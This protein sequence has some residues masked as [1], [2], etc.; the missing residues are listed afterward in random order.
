MESVKTYEQLLEE[1][2]LL[3]IR[4]EEANDTLEAIRSGEVD[5]LVVKANDSHQLYT[6]K[7][8]DQTYR[9]FIEQMTEGV[10]TL[11]SKN[12]ILYCN[13]R[14]A[15]MVG[16][17]LEKIIG[18]EFCKFILQD[19]WHACEQL[20]NRAWED[21]SRGELN[22][23]GSNAE[24]FPVLMSCKRLDL[25]GNKS[26]S[27]IL[28]DLSTQKAQ[29]EELL[30]KNI[31]LAEAE[32][33]ARY[34]N[35]NLESLVSLRTAELEK[36]ILE[37]TYI[38]EQLSDN[39]ERLTQIL[40]TMAEG[41]IIMNI[42]GG[43][44]YANS[45]AKKALDISAADE[46]NQLFK[47]LAE[48]LTME[49]LPLQ[50]TEHPMH[51]SMQ[52]GKA[53]FDTEIGVLLPGKEQF[54][55]LMNAAPVFDRN[56]IITGSIGT[57]TDVTKRRIAIRQKD[58]FIGVASHELK[59]PITVLKSSVQLLDK[60]KDDPSNPMI[61]ALIG[62]ANKGLKKLGHLVEDLLDVSR[63]KEGHLILNEKKF[64]V[65]QML[66][67]SLADLPM[68]VAAKV[69]VKGNATLELFAD[70]NRI[71]QVVINFINNAVK[72]APDTKEIIIDVVSKDGLVKISITDSGPGIE[73]EK[74]SQIFERY[75]RT[76]YSHSQ[77][78]GLGLG[79][80]ISAE[81]VKKHGGTI[82]VDSELGK[83]SAFWFELPLNSA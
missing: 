57:F 53:V 27:I 83:G 61:P 45:L 32:Q 64:N 31:Q 55:I 59:T 14:F 22:V 18:H 70:Q 66:Q 12:N 79:L 7:S 26:M 25:D 33:T 81:I 30:E 58:D 23:S 38:S 60:L 8:A 4:L 2:E 6:L 54:Y 52:T 29:Q 63:L 21:N 65:R 73:K 19:E 49:G 3:K 34:L 39:Q 43:I 5:A 28:T 17:P 44:V 41:V 80:Y 50:R 47:T 15:S 1:V 76:D 46:S 40:E 11:N 82:G 42:D 37:K 48:G 68:S 74:Q 56:D 67:E 51:I 75:Y 16:Q 10:V 13:S 35:T 9:I 36:T 20:I 72:Y 62:Q 69:Q 77:H 24:I 71:E 78:T